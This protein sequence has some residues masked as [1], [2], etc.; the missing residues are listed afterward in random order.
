MVQVVELTVRQVD[1]VWAVTPSIDDG[2]TQGRWAPGGCL[3][4][5]YDVNRGLPFSHPVTGRSKLGSISH[6]SI[7]FL[8]FVNPPKSWFFGPHEVPVCALIA[9]VT[10]TDHRTPTKANTN[11]HALLAECTSM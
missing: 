3:G 5:G 8:G 10:R 9:H 7:L 4:V 11:S 6:I 1:R 2:R